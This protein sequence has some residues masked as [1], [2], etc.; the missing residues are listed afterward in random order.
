[1][2]TAR[3]GPPTEVTVLVMTL[4]PSGEYDVAVSPSV[5]ADPKGWGRLIADLPERIARTYNLTPVGYARLVETIR[6][7]AQAAWVESESNTAGEENADVI[8]FRPRR[9]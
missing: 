8:P 2:S 4:L 7:T 5:F 3:T 6:N 1:M 9:P